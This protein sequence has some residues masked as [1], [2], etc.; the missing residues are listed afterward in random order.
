MIKKLLFSIFL[1]AFFS[2]AEARPL[3][4]VLDW[5]INPDHAPLLVAEQQGFF[6][7]ENLQVKIIQP[8]DPS[9]GP[10]LV[11]AGKADIAIDYQPA[12]L[13]Q[14]EQGL[15]L[16]RFGVLVDSP[17]D[18]LVTLKSADI[19]RIEDLKGKTVG[20]SAGGIDSAM[21]Q[22]MLR[23]HQMSFADIHFINV[24]FDL[25]QGLLTKRIDAFTGGMR[26]VEPIEL[27]IL[28]HPAQVFYPEKNGFPPYDE[29]IFVTNRDKKSDPW[30]AG[31]L[32]A[33]QR[34]TEYLI[35]HPGESWVAVIKQHPELNNPVNKAS[36][37]ASIKYFAR[38]P[39]T[40]DKAKYQAFTQFMHKQGVIK[41]IPNLDDYTVVPRGTSTTAPRST[42]NIVPL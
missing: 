37:M 5:F 17:L 41:K 13:M 10:K 36:W 18:C 28:G 34:G 22:T 24:S 3:T 11:A 35:A 7:Q 33:V 30:L 9:D 21:M 1:A 19:Q 2:F 20:Y 38:N 15:P 27:D 6:Q 26:N 39:A 8:S 32:R 12:L 23:N 40:L 14:L 4:V 31:F 16:V 42:W 25:V 29:L